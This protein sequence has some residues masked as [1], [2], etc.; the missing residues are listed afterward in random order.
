MPALPTAAPGLGG[1]GRASGREAAVRQ[2][3]PGVGLASVLLIVG[4]GR[5]SVSLVSFGLSRV[6]LLG[7][8]GQLRRLAGAG[9]VRAGVDVARRG[10]LLGDRGLGGS[11][12]AARPGGRRLSPPGPTA[13]RLRC[14]ILANQL[15]HGHGGVVA[16]ARADLGD[17]RVAACPL[18]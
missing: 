15:D 16:L 6:G 9:L 10:R 18:A 5:L 11:R 14:R 13:L 1:P 2:L 8:V 7:S 4:L 12:G 3:L 17:P